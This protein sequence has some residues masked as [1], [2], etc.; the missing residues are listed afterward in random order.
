M[1]KV[2]KMFF[3][4]FVLIVFIGTFLSCGTTKKVNTYMDKS[5]PIE[6]HAR[7]SFHIEFSVAK[8]DNIV[9]NPWKGT[10]LDFQSGGWPAGK[11]TVCFIPAGEHEFRL[12][13]SRKT[14]SGSAYES[15]LTAE[16]ISFKY[17]FLP[18][19]LYC[20]YPRVEGSLIQ[21]Q[22]LD[23]TNITQE[24]LDQLFGVD[25]EISPSWIWYKNQ[26]LKLKTET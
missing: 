1:M 26:I 18:G 22:V 17:N 19:H 15:Y 16:N 21:V 20:I 10:L 12:D 5:V 6:E 14:G 11:L 7:V 2:S 24:E 25:S 9:K 3:Y 4:Y 8:Y 13:F 23:A